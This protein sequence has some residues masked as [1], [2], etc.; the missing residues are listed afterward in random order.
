MMDDGVHSVL[1]FSHKTHLDTQVLSGE[2][3]C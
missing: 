1:D 2:G 3:I